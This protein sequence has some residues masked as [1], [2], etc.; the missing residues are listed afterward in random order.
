[1]MGP[2]FI[3]GVL[4]PWGASSEKKLSSVVRKEPSLMC[5]LLT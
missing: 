5:L 3:L 1:M 2:T 4:R